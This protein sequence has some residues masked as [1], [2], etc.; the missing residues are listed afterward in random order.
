VSILITLI[1]TIGVTV[2]FVLNGNALLI[3][4]SKFVAGT[5]ATLFITQISAI[6][7]P[8]ADIRLRNT[9]GIVGG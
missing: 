5:A 1:I 7:Q 9:F 4:A 3:F 2:A 6:V 8:V